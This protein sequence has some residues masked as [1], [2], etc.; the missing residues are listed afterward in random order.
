MSGTAH[1]VLQKT[2]ALAQAA[3]TAREM[4]EAACLSVMGAIDRSHIVAVLVGCQASKQRL[5]LC[6]S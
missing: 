5:S 1:H 3:R 4:L 2:H 6:D